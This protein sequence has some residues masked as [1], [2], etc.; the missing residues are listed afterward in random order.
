MP[1]HV[2][3]ISYGL[4][5]SVRS[6]LASTYLEVHAMT[7]G[8]SMMNWYA[9]WRTPGLQ[10]LRSA[11]LLLTT[12][13]RRPNNMLTLTWNPRR[14]QWT[15]ILADVDKSVPEISFTSFLLKS[16][17]TASAHSKLRA[18]GIAADSQHCFAARSQKLQT[19]TLARSSRSQDPD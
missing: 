17:P 19:S 16:R 3:R 7:A 11:R 4:T 1:R 6:L 15:C 13:R 5:R 12:A 2:S 18:I 10:A 8:R 14:K 9:D